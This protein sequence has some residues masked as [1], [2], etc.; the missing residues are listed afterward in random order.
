MNIFHRISDIISA[1]F[2]DMLEKYENPEQMLRQAIRETETAIATARK[3]VAAAMASEKTIGKELATNEKQVELWQTRA[4]SAVQAGDD[5][6]AK[7]AI[8]RR[9]EYEKVATALKDHHAAALEASQS[10]RR[11]FDAMQAKLSEAE[12]RLQ[13]LIARNRAA[14]IRTKLASTEVQLDVAPGAFAK[15]DRMAKKVERVEAEAE[16]MAE[17]AKSMPISSAAKFEKENIE[18]TLESMEVDAELARMKAQLSPKE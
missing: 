18:S 9:K 11:Q 10:L 7:K 8:E 13:T 4:S 2:N 3:D 14:E 5:G 16:A 17:L 15:F 1:N 12:R 6:L